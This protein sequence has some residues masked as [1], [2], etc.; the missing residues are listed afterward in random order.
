MVQSHLQCW[1]PTGQELCWVHQQQRWQPADLQRLWALQVSASPD[2]GDP[3]LGLAGWG[4]GTAAVRTRGSLPWGLWV[5]AAG[6]SR[7]VSGTAPGA[8]GC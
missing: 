1:S 7:R 4:G 2:A 8:G 3:R 5:C 6:W